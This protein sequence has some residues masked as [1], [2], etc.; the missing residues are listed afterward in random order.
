MMLRFWYN[1]LHQPVI[2]AGQT[3]K[4]MT[5]LTTQQNDAEQKTAL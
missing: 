5:K 3:Q 1:G 4:D 2:L